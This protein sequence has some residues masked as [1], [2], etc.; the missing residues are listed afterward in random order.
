MAQ[1]AKI[2]KIKCL[3][4]LG[5]I[6]YLIIFW[7]CGWISTFA[8][9]IHVTINSDVANALTL[10]TEIVHFL[11]SFNPDPTQ[12][13]S[14]WSLVIGGM[15]NTLTIFGIGQTS[16]QRYCALPSLKQAKRWVFG[17]PRLNE[18]CLCDWHAARLGSNIVC[19]SKLHKAWKEWCL[20]YGAVVPCWKDA[21]Y[22]C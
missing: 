1:I 7:A 6:Q 5:V 11:H 15:V 13:L 16:V 21:R 3:L 17:S 10:D 19:C 20:E 4:K 22:G 18:P 14:I 9:Y 12:R 2:T 8:V